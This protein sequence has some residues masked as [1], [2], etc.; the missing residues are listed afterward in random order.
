MMPLDSPAERQGYAPPRARR[1]PA[2]VGTGLVYA[3]GLI[4]FFVTVSRVQPIVAPSPLT[5]ISVLPLAA[6]KA[7]PQEKE[8]ERPLRKKEPQRQPPAAQAVQRT[9][10]PTAPAAAPVP[11]PKA[12][13]ADPG[14]A[15]PETAAPRTTATPAPQPSSNAADSWEGRLLAALHRHRR[16]PASARMRRQQGVPYIRFV[17]DREGRVLS[18]R[19]ERSSGFADL[20]REAVALPKRAQP[21]PKAPADRPG[22]TLELVVPVEFFLR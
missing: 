5:V 18:A 4:G 14:P 15:A 20:D 17:M 11:S 21:L 10:V 9:L 22:A 8:A 19:L 12:H 16:Y 13:P 6:P 1:V 2:L 7:P 3:L